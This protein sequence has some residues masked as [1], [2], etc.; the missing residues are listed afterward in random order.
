MAHSVNSAAGR[1]TCDTSLFCASLWYF[2]H[3]LQ[4]LL[5]APPNLPVCPLQYRPTRTN[6]KLHS[7]NPSPRH[8]AMLPVHALELEHSAVPNLAIKPLNLHPFALAASRSRRSQVLL[9][10]GSFG[11]TIVKAIPLIRR[12]ERRRFHLLRAAWAMKD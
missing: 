4:L 3:R 5:H 12:S 9:A 11:L 6:S 10:P 7:T 2:S 1:G 8:T